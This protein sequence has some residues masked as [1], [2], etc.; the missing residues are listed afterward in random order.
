MVTVKT[1]VTGLDALVEKTEK[2][3]DQMENG[4]GSAVMLE[5]GEAA[6][7]DIEERFKTRGYGTWQPLKPATIMRKGHDTILVDTGTMKGAVG[8]GAVSERRVT[9]VVPYGGGRLSKDVPPRHQRGT[10][11]VPQRKIVEVTDRLLA[12]IN[13]IIMKWVGGL[14][15]DVDDHARLG[16]R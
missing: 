6:V 15:E 1:A 9:A 16:W 8:I 7:E 5:V 2:L 10:E 3:V 13:P 14:M 4:P 12:R 11:T